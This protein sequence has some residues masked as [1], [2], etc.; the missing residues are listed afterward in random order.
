MRLIWRVVLRVA[1]ALSLLLALW[2]GLF[3]FALMDEVN[4]EVDDSLEHYA[5]MLIRRQLR[6][7]ELPPAGFGTNGYRIEPVSAED[8][9]RREEPRY[10][11]REIYIPQEGETEPARVLT[12]RFRDRE[13]AWYR[14]TVYTPTIE[15]DDLREAI[16]HWVVGLYAGLLLTVT[17]ICGWVFY[18]SMRPLY[19]LLE[20][21]DGYRVGGQN[22]PLAS[23]TRIR[24]FRRL[25]E[26]A[27]RNAARAEATFREQK[28]FIGNASHEMQTPLAI[29]RNRLELLADSGG[30]TEE[31]LREVAATQRMLDYMVRLNRSLLFLS[32]IENGQFPESTAV[33]LGALV[34]RCLEE[35]SEIHAGRRIGATVTQTGTLLGMMNE[36]L[37]QSLVTN[38]LRNAFVHTAP[39]GTIRVELGGGV[40]R[41]CNSGEQPLDGSRIF[42]RFYQSVRREGSTGL[43]LAI[44]DAICKHYGLGLE[45]RFVQGEH[46]FEVRFDAAT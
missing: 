13:G 3:Y 41:V 43:G 34:R 19:R 24:E 45:Y 11:D 9:A 36:S 29:C 23:D 37:A 14:M 26:A 1:L 25:N 44:V 30:L 6:G 15:K 38:L 2:A 8:A 20:W 16:L 22:S 33:D 42:A 35:L 40:L 31:Q 12:T 10:A 4:D 39:G 7:E 46:C 32:K 28:Q 18:R 27:M 21:L 5:Q 17:L